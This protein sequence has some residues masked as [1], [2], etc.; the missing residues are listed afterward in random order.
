MRASTVLLAVLASAAVSQAAHAS[1]HWSYIVPG[2]CGIS[3]EGT[4]SV[5]S[6]AFLT[7]D[8]GGYYYGNTLNRVITCE[9]RVPQGAVIT[10]VRV[11]GDDPRSGGYS[12]QW[13]LSVLN[14]QH[15][16]QGTFTFNGNSTLGTKTVWSSQI[17][18]PVT[19][20]NEN[21]AYLVSLYTSGGVSSI[22]R[23]IE[24]AYSL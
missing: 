4:T 8:V 15:P 22:T 23:L 11:W 12:I 21:N 17:S 3:P 6:T 10:N 24:I 1:A 13:Y 7:G 14:Y 18:N 19:V 5:G 2:S 20:D 9:V 16:D